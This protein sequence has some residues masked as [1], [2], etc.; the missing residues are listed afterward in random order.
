MNNETTDSGATVPCISLLGGSH[1]CD[2]CAKDFPTCDADKIVWGID[3][4]P[5]ARGAEA[6]KVLECDGYTPNDKAQGSAA[7]GASPGATG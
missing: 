3:R 1:K 2:T 4:D 5:A 6:D 7:C